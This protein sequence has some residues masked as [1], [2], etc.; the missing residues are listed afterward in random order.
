MPQDAP[1]TTQQKPATANAVFEITGGLLFNADHGDTWAYLVIGVDQ[2][3]P[4]PAH[5]ASAHAETAIDD[6]GAMVTLGLGLDR[7]GLDALIG[8]LTGV[9]DQWQAAA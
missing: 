6:D 7:D 2:A 9:R 3:V 4:T 8:Y 5:R 1:P